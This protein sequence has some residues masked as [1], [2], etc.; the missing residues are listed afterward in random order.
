MSVNDTIALESVELDDAPARLAAEDPAPVARALARA[1][2]AAARHGIDHHSV[3]RALRRTRHLARR[4]P[5]SQGAWLLEAASLRQSDAAEL[6][7]AFRRHGVSGVA[8]LPEAWAYELRALIDRL[9]A[10]PEREGFAGGL[11]RLGVRRLWPLDSAAP[12][13]RRT[14]L[15]S[16]VLSSL[17]LLASETCVDPALREVAAAGLRAAR[18]LTG[19][20]PRRMEVL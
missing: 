1:L 5:S 7:A 6:A 15:A 10:Q 9:A 8:L 16:C 17:E 18:R 2:A 12:P 4:R 13:P 11:K 19:G 20:E 14:D 3:R